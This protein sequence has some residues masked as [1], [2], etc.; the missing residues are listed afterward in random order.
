[1]T[2]KSGHQSNG[3]SAATNVP[4]TP[5]PANMTVL[6]GVPATPSFM[7]STHAGSVF[8]WTT[9]NESQSVATNSP[10]PQTVQKTK[11]AQMT[12]KEQEKVMY[13]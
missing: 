4:Q 12:L 7:K 9:G 5:A 8:G 10:V 13:N 6:T 1:M 3:A 2:S 11:A